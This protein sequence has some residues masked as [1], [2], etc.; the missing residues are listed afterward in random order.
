MYNLSFQRRYDCLKYECKEACHHARNSLAKFHLRLCFIF[1][2]LGLEVVVAEWITRLPCKA[3]VRG[4][5]PT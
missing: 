2:M 3:R 1:C 5:K 4:S